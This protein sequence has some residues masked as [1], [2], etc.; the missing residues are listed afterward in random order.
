MCIAEALD[1][2][3]G[4]GVYRSLKL[5]LRDSIAMARERFDNEPGH[6]AEEDTGRSILVTWLLFFMAALG[7][8]GKLLAM[9]GI[10][11]PKPLL[12]SI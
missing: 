11:V 1:L 9:N 5:P 7:P 8:G 3:L 2:M 6:K 12:V 10:P 4:V